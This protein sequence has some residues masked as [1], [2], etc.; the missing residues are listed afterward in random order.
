M[1]K[2][3]LSIDSSNHTI[4]NVDSLVTPCDQFEKNI[5]PS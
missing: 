4:G 3:P 2:S 1:T 5:D